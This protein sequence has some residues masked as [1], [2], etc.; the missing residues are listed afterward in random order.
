LLI[1]PVGYVL[2]VHLLKPGEYTDASCRWRWIVRAA[3]ISIG[4]CGKHG[5]QFLCRWLA[6]ILALTRRRGSTYCAG[7]AFA[8]MFAYRHRFHLRRIAAAVNR[9]MMWSAPKVARMFFF[10]R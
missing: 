2:P 1:R 8:A 5:D 9:Q 10:K 6:I 3:E 7:F 4:D